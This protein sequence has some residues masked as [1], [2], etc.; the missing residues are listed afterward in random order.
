MTLAAFARLLATTPKWVLN[1]L[2]ALDRHP[3]Y[4]LDLARR[5]A[6]TREIHDTFGVPLS[7]AFALAQQALRQT[8]VAE[9]LVSVSSR[10]DGNVSLT[11]DLYRL[12]S[13][14][15]VRLAEL[16]ESYAPPVLGRPRTRPVDALA[17]AEDWGLD[18]SLVRDNMRKTHH[19]RLRQLDAMHSFATRVRR[20]S[21]SAS[22]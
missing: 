22:T 3:R 8:P 20:D 9:S 14:F 19:E 12:L 17:A 4:T 21:T 5:L 13:S 11:I 2:H 1:T 7:T 16:R 6:V 15:N 18:L 10:A